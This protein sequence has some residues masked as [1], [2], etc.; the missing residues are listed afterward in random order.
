VH[1]TNVQS[2]LASIPGAF[3]G[4]KNKVQI[5][6]HYNHYTDKLVFVCLP[7]AD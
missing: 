2:F 7:L 1:Q 4:M 5:Q 3:K 6:H